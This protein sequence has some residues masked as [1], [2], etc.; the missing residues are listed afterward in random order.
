MSCRSSGG[1]RGS[2]SCSSPSSRSAHCLSPC[3]L[4]GPLVCSPSFD[5]VVAAT[6]TRLG[7]NFSPFSS[8]PF[9]RVGAQKRKRTRNSCARAEG[10]DGSCTR[11]LLYISARTTAA[12]RRRRCRSSGV[13]MK[14]GQTALALHEGP[15][16]AS[17]SGPF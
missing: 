5:K 13:Q 2:R 8:R 1:D 17:N 4:F 10:D 15:S 12:S 7:G 11:P 6:G 14:A 3:L 16:C 9:Q